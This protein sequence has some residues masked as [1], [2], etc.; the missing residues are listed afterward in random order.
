MRKT[1]FRDV[2]GG[3]VKPFASLHPLQKD[4]LSPGTPKGKGTEG[5]LKTHIAVS[6]IQILSRWQIVGKLVR[7][8]QY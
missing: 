7:L 2:G 8:A 6:W 5:G 4:N 3:Y 1:S